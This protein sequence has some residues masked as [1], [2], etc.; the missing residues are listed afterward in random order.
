MEEWQT[1]AISQKDTFEFY[2]WTDALDVWI[3]NAGDVPI[4]VRVR[5][6][7]WEIPPQKMLSVKRYVY[8]ELKVD[9][10]L[11]EILQEST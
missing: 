5:G 4:E 7:E 1:T 10:E 3:E 2:T 8:E 6:K 9:V 11:P